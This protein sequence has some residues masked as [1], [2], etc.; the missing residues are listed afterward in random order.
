MKSL[1][2]AKCPS[3]FTDPDDRNHVSLRKNTPHR[4]LLTIAVCSC[5]VDTVAAVIKLLPKLLLDI[6][7]RDASTLLH[8]AGVSRI[9]SPQTPTPN[10]P[11]SAVK[12]K[13]SPAIIDSLVA[14]GVR[15]NALNKA[16]QTAL[17]NCPTT[18]PRIPNQTFSKPPK[19]LRLPLATCPP[20][21]ACK[22]TWTAPKRK[23]I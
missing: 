12:A 15:P 21:S 4:S 7:P 16:D 9:M 2:A 22:N 23:A 5:M 14:A 10:P 13:A 11:P 18:K 1:S 20:C 6:D 19:I 8:A 17:G 3:V